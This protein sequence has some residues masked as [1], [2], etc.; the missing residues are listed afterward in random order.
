MDITT[1]RACLWKK[2]ERSWQALVTAK[3]DAPG[4]RNKITLDAPRWNESSTTK[5]H[6]LVVSSS[7]DSDSD[8]MSHDVL[9]QG[10]LM[11]DVGNRIT[12]K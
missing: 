9:A 11:V 7:D 10:G 2:I 12:T 5:K 1:A 8:H 3:E 4:S 6:W